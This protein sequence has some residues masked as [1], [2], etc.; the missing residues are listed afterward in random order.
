M[1][2]GPDQSRS[3]VSFQ[4]RMLIPAVPEEYINTGFRKQYCALLIGISLAILLALMVILCATILFFG[5]LRPHNN[6]PSKPVATPTVPHQQKKS[7]TP[8]PAVSPSP[9]DQQ[10]I[11]FQLGV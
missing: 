3:E 1:Q 2:P 7:P 8:V 5:P 10:T 6:T 4:S 9:A 11:S